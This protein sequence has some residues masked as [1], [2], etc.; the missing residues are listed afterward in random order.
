LTNATVGFDGA[1]VTSRA[2]LFDA[3]LDLYS[4]EHCADGGATA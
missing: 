2:V 4:L 1:K 3:N